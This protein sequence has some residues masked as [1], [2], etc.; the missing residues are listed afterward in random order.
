MLFLLAIA[1]MKWLALWVALWIPIYIFAFFPQ[2]GY[3]PLTGISVLEM[4]Q[5]AGLLGVAV[6]ATLRSV[7]RI[8]AAF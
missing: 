6:I 1:G 7:Q 3:F 4:D 8:Y 2:M 5:L